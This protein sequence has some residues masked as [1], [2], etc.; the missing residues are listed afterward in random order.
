MSEVS[1]L[2]AALTIL[3]GRPAPSKIIEALNDVVDPLEIRNAILKRPELFVFVPEFRLAYEIGSLEAARK[4]GTI[5]LVIGAAG[6]SP[7][8]WV[9]TN[10]KLLNLLKPDAWAVWL[11]DNSVDAMLAEHV[12]EH[13]TIDEGIVAARTCF[14]F[15]KPGSRLRIAVP[16][17][18]MPDPD[19]HRHCDVGNGN[20]H[21][22]FYDYK[23]LV[24]VLSSVGFNCQL[25]EWWDE[26]GSFSATE[27][28]S[29]DGPIYRSKRYDHRNKNGKLGYTS[30]IIDC[31][32]PTV[33]EIL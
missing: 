30:L 7:K 14:R 26:A 32:K 31:F 28:S 22:V 19:Y 12:W 25:L 1:P 5:N 29:S 2:S 10:E 6:T 9:S 18:L 20:G 23:T 11:D 16:D 24:S 4:S 8:G 27:W 33:D 17:A 3:T 13:L 15:L 21:Q